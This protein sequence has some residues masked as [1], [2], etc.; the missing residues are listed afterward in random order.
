MLSGDSHN[1]W[2]FDLD[3]EG[4]RA[5]VEFAGQSVTSPGYE[6]ELPHVAPAAIARAAITRNP[7]LKYADTSRRGYMTLRLTPRARDRGVA[8]PRH[9]PPALDADC[10]AA[11]DDRPARE[12]PSVLSVEGPKRR[13]A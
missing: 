7:Q 1:A 12:Q 4:A 13:L 2:G 11:R 10:G 8:V 6:S 3:L 5:G 9:D